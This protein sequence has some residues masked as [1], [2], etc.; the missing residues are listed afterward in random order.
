METSL[1]FVV[2]DKDKCRHCLACR[3]ACPSGDIEFVPFQEKNGRLIFCQKQG[4]LYPEY[5]CS[6]CLE[7]DILPAC[8][9]ACPEKALKIVNVRQERKTKNQQAVNY[10]YKYWGGK[11]RS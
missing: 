2:G 9:A 10:L 11:K 4:R 3:V 1:S 8:I 6:A 5:I 7:S